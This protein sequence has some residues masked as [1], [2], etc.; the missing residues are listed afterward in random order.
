M[1]KTDKV[2]LI[3]NS[4]LNYFLEGDWTMLD[5]SSLNHLVKNADY[6]ILSE[7]II[8]END[9]IYNNVDWAR[10]DRSKIIRIISR[11]T[12]IVDVI[13]IESI[14]NYNFTI[15]ESFHILKSKPEIIKYLSIN[16]ENPTKEEVKMLLKIGNKDL[17]EKVDINKVEFNDKDT[18]EIIDY[19][20]FKDSI[21]KMVDL[22]VLSSYYI[23]E[24][25]NFSY[26][27]HIDKLNIDKI[28][29]KHWCEILY[30]NS[31]LLSYCNLE[32]FKEADIFYTVLLI[33]LF[34]KLVY[35]I[36][37]RSG[38]K[39]EL[40]IMGWEKLVIAS[41]KFINECPR[42][43]FNATNWKKIVSRHPDLAAYQL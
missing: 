7:S 3:V 12:D 42:H 25:I 17:I 2:K 19:N 23:A 14:K 5:N 36:K 13:G 24:I 11:N 30:L 40:S 35:L 1:K 39:E 18:Y 16:F 8:A 37:E 4:F 20:H 41:P 15:S 32:I 10:M 31:D 6:N 33:E 9:S 27:S 29:P 43:R 28:K 26:K 38:Y 34:P 22:D 21:F